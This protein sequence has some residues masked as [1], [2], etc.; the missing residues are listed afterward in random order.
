[1]S[2]ELR[3]VPLDLSWPD[4]PRIR[5]D[6]SHLFAKT[7]KGEGWQ[8]WETV[9]EGSPISPVYATATELVDWAVG[10]DGQLGIGGTPVS[11]KASEAFVREGWAP[12]MVVQGGE[13]VGG[14]EWLAR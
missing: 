14:V 5:W 2:R 1:M 8:A 6:E 4:D 9:S 10:P 12:T 7:P 11:R 13:V 3:R